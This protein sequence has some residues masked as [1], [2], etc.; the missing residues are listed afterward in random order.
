MHLGSEKSHQRLTQV[1]RGGNASARLGAA[2][3]KHPART[4]DV[5]FAP[6]LTGRGSD[7]APVLHRLDHQRFQLVSV[8]EPTLHQ[9]Q[10]SPPSPV[11]PSN[12]IA[13]VPSLCACACRRT[14]F[15]PASLPS[16]ART[17]RAAATKLRSPSSCACC[18]GPAAAASRDSSS[19]CTPRRLFAAPPSPPQAS[20][21]S[22]CALSVTSEL[23]RHRRRRAFCACAGRSS[24]SREPSTTT[25]S[26][27][28]PAGACV[29]GRRCAGAWVAQTGWARAR[30]L[31]ARMQ[32]C[33]TTRG[34]RAS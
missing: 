26:A 4:R 34:Q 17:L 31:R 25:S 23:R 21:R 8:S 2:L 15:R 13:N 30:R 10:A 18:S 32:R 27:S 3:P 22:R 6:S 9:I 19:H 7:A 16:R 12:F 24:A 33:S 11:A 1:A 14:F 28:P 20:P 5:K 29:G